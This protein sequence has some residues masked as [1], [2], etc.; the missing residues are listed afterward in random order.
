MTGSSNQGYKA[1]ASKKGGSGS[2]KSSQG[3]GRG[4]NLSQEARSK[5]GRHS[6]GGSDKK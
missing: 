4:S 1:S 3:K 6:H 5:G 2:Q